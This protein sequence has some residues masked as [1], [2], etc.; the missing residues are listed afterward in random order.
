M[1]NSFFFIELMPDKN[2]KNVEKN[3]QKYYKKKLYIKS[4]ESSWFINIWIDF[5]FLM[6]F[7]CSRKI[8]N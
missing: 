2:D 7:L 4:P 6:Q 3:T 5:V 8:E 1:W